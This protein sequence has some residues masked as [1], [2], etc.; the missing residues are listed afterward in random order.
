MHFFSVAAGEL[1][2][3]LKAAAESSAVF[4]LFCQMP[5]LLLSQSKITFFIC[6]KKKYCCF[7]FVTFKYS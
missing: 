4:P 5:D 6:G 2:G 3:T 1:E 7:S